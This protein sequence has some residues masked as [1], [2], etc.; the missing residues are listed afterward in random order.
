MKRKIDY[1]RQILA[2]LGSTLVAFSGGVDSSLLLW[3]ARDVLGPENVVALTASGSLFP[4]YEY[5][6]AQIFAKELGVRLLNIDFGVLSLPQ[7][8][9]NPYNRCYIC[10]KELL[11]ICWAKASELGMRQVVDGSNYDDLDDFR[12]GMKATQELKV[13]TPLLEAQLTKRDIRRWSK[14]LGLSVWDKPASP[15]LATRF[16]YGIPITVEGLKKIEK[17]EKF[18][19]QLGLRVVR[20]RVHHALARIEVGHRDLAK[21]IALRGKIIRR[22][23]RIGFSCI[24]LDIEGYRSQILPEDTDDPEKKTK[25]WY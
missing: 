23:K 7:F 16:P 25:K 13:K 14:R 15:C 20:V 5:K 1:L 2:H 9:E 4:E 24:T 18:L 19:K 17:S 3:M 6:E 10:K 12:P 11:T 21:V 22:L 8:V